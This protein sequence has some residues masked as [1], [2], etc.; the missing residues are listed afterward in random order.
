MVQAAAEAAREAGLANV[1]ARVMDAEEIDLAPGSFD[2]V[3]SRLGL[4]FLGRLDRALRAMRRVLVPGG[5]LAAVVY[6]SPERNPIFSLL[7]PV[8]WRH[9]GLRRRSLRRLS[10]L[11]LGGPGVLE[12]AYR[13]TGFRAVAAHPVPIVLRLGS[14][15]ECLRLVQETVV[16]I[17]SVLAGAGEA[18]RAAAWAEMGRVLA[19]FEGPGGFAI[20]GEVLVGVGTKP[21]YSATSRRA[22]AEA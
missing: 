16:P 7:A 3:V 21:D 12:A 13:R 11:R 10:V 1:A 15:D 5:R 6:A 14:A 9:A 19:R 2:A 22:R 17:T 4:M 18:R 8:A 20:P